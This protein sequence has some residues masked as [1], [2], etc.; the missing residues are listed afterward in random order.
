MKLRER[1]PE[2]ALEGLFVVFAILLA[3]AADEWR[4]N[5]QNADIAERAL[6]GIE[7]EM[8]ANRVE[9]LN[10]REP[11]LE[12]LG[13][14]EA[15][16]EDDAAASRLSVQF[17][18]SL[19]SSAAWQTAQVTQAIHY[20]DYNLV[21]QIAKLYDLQGLFTESQ[22]GMVQQMTGVGGD[23]DRFVESALGHLR[24]VMGV[25]AGYMAVLDTMIVQMANR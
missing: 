21:Q 19:L 18:Y 15:E 20:A 2:V 17:E 6:A 23:A 24:I 11:N 8:L 4:D 7:T 10:S 25:E 22:R 13:R 9:L 12:L 14:L 3:L 1:L 16:V 5:R